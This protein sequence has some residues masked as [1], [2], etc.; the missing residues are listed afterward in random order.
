VKKQKC[1]YLLIV[2]L[3]CLI[4][5]SPLLFFSCVDEAGGEEDGEVVE[6]PARLYVGGFDTAKIYVVN[7]TLKEVVQTIDLPTDARPD[8]LAL[9]PDNK[10]LYCSSE[11]QNKIYIVDVV[12]NSYETSVDVANAPRGIAFTPDGTTAAVVCSGGND[13]ALIDTA[14]PGY[15]FSATDT[16]FSFNG[17][18]GI[19]IHPTN[20]KLYATGTNSEIGYADVTGGVTAS[21]FAVPFNFGG[22]IVDVALRG[23]NLF[24]TQQDVPDNY[25]H[26]KISPADGSVS[27]STTNPLSGADF[28]VGKITKAPDGQRLYAPIFS[29][30]RIDYFSPTDILT[31]SSVDLSAYTTTFTGPRDVALSDDSALA[32][33]LIDSDDDLIVILDTSDNSVLGTISL[34]TDS[35]PRSLVYKP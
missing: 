28:S 1:S 9:S 22:L 29:D 13:I 8:W 34:P 35:N 18:G 23:N 27:I 3:V 2:V 16:V 32:F 25:I 19:A 15:T 14:S 21:T 33:A 26:L 20:N 4:F 6:D 24:V 7:P 30:S 31:V 10:K 17:Q 12:T 5:S 11:A